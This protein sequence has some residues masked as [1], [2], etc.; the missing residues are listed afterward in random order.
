MTDAPVLQPAHTLVPPDELT[1][2]GGFV[3]IDGDRYARI[4]AVDA[5]PPFFMS[6]VSD[7]DL[8]LFVGSNGAFTAGRKDPDHGLFPSQTVDKILRD[9]DASGV[10]S[11][12]LVNRGGHTS[13]WEPWRHDGGLCQADRASRRPDGLFHS[14][15]ILKLAGASRGPATGHDRP[16]QGADPDQVR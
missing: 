2:D 7:S 16:G 8:W 10:R 11:A 12:F 5:M 3:T 4:G 1:V 13:L 14:Y 6:V 9:A 15:D